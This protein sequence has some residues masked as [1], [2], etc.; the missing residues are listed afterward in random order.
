MTHDDDIKTIRDALDVYRQWSCECDGDT[1][2]CDLALA[3]LERLEKSAVPDGWV[4]TEEMKR[5]GAA[6]MWEENKRGEVGY[7]STERVFNAMI[8]AIAQIEG[9]R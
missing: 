1:D 4:L 2:D 6:Q 5:R 3:A 8:A 7:E 9:E